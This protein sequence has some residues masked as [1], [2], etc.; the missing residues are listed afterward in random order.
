MPNPQGKRAIQFSKLRFSPP[1]SWAASVDEG[2]VA[3]DPID[4][5]ARVTIWQVGSNQ[6]TEQTLNQ[7]VGDRVLVVGTVVHLP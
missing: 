2:L 7:G 1:E 4:D 3:Y 6:T 5:G